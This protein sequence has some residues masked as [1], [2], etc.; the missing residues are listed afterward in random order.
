MICFAFFHWHQKS[1]RV[2]GGQ[3]DSNLAFN[4]SLKL[5]PRDGFIQTP[6][7]TAECMKPSQDLAPIPPLFLFHS[8]FS[9]FF[10]SQITAVFDVLQKTIAGASV[11][12]YDSN[13]SLANMN[14]NSL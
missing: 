12:F 9:H 11:L 3:P 4:G 14:L 7:K 1:L 10:S 8:C 13:L 5:G 6:T 2:Q